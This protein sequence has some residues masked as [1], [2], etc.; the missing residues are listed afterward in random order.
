[1]SAMLVA[2]TGASGFVG[3]S[4]VAGLRARGHNCV[5][6]DRAAIGDISGFTSWPTVLS[7]EDAVVHLAALAHSAH[8]DEERVR[9]V[10]V[11]A[12]AAVGRA[13]AK[14]GLRMLFMNSV[15]VLGEDKGG[16]PF[17]TG[18][19][20]KPQDAYGPAKA[21]AES[22]L[23]GIPGLNLTVLRP[24]LVYGPGVKANFLALFHAVARG[25][26]LPFASI[27]NRRSLIGL[28]N[29][30]DAVSRCIEMPDAA[31]RIYLVTDGAPISTPALCRAIVAALGV[32][33]RLFPFPPALL[34]IAAPARKL[35]R[36]LRVDDGAIQLEL[37]WEFPVA[38][39][40]ELRR[41]AERFRGRG[42]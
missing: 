37:G 29:L 12:A 21:M 13:A 26:P 35:T 23:R 17:G 22:A 25:W 40:E 34:E 11:D 20:V 38:F 2:V 1:M 10:N 18:S 4:V 16:L 39:E 3:R 5:A 14:L 42:G 32:R 27:D 28:S 19:P 8:V 33:T 9:A 24:P 6:P 31:G 30:A 15:K 41:T 7:D 36:S